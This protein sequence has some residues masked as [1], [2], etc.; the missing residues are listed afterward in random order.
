MPRALEQKLIIWKE[1]EDTTKIKGKAIKEGSSMFIG[2]ILLVFIGGLFWL[3]VG[4]A[5]AIF[6][7]TIGTILSIIFYVILIGS[8]IGGP[9]MILMGAFKIIASLLRKSKPIICPFCGQKFDL[10]MNVTN[11]YCLK[12]R[13]K[14]F[15]TTTKDNK[16]IKSICQYCSN[17]YGVSNQIKSF[18]CPNCG[19]Q[20][21]L[22]GESSKT[23]TETSCIKCGN[24]IPKS[25][26]YC[27]NCLEVQNLNFFMEQ[28]FEDII[29]KT[30]AG[31]LA[32]ANAL[33][34]RLK[35]KTNNIEEP[36]NSNFSSAK[37][38]VEF[39]ELILTS[40][41]EALEEESFASNISLRLIEIEYA[42]LII[43]RKILIT[44]NSLNYHDKEFK[45]SEIELL[46][47]SSHIEIYNNI[48]NKLEKIIP[49]D[50]KIKNLER[51]ETALFL[52]DEQPSTKSPGSTEYKLKSIEPLKK[53]IQRFEKKL[54]RI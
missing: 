40:Y 26:A 44:L 23:L 41:Q 16:M 29:P 51:L 11:F 32:Y 33:V 28:S 21:D 5:G 52:F 31:H 53:E 54:Q 35:D 50:P 19:L 34:S 24:S 17:E 46:K 18:I 48:L 43:L 8:L 49:A 2:G 7:K 37:Q 15:F 14:L 25:V 4:Y 13:K 38:V 27:R 39:L 3:L 12:S 30:K 42:Y 9:I 10:F 36:D 1:E 45:S 22:S 47:Y 20:N 6:G